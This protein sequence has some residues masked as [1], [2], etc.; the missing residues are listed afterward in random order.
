ME[1]LTWFHADAEEKQISCIKLLCAL[2]SWKSS[3]TYITH[4]FALAMW[5][6]GTKEMDKEGVEER[7]EL[8]R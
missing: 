8:L 4:S 1:D 6:L 2:Q 3:K 5:Q 7:K